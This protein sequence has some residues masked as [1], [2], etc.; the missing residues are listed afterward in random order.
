MG[1][2]GSHS[3]GGANAERLLNAEARGDVCQH[4]LKRVCPARSLLHGLGNPYVCD[5][6]C[7]E[8]NASHLLVIPCKRHNLARRLGAQNRLMHDT[9]AC[10]KLSMHCDCS[11]E[12][13]GELQME[14]YL[15]T[16]HMWQWFTC[17]LLAGRCYHLWGCRLPS[18][19]VSDWSCRL[20]FP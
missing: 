17:E 5:C 15:V 2:G 7:T 20:Y 8:I 13:Q 9:A 16:L 4:G 1:G 10:A 14:S 6:P 19:Y 18:Y 3:R 12:Q 11:D